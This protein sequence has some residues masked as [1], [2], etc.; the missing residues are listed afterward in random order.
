MTVL[1]IEEVVD[2]FSKT[3]PSWQRQANLQ[4]L[5]RTH[6]SLKDG[7]IWMSPNLGTIY[8]RAGDGFELVMSMGEVDV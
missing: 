5:E 4:F 6:A 1:S 2:S 8:K 3:L 7:G